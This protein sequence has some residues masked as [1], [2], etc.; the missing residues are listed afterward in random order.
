MRSYRTTSTLQRGSRGQMLSARLRGRRPRV[1]HGTRLRNVDTTV[2]TLAQDGR[3]SVACL[4]WPHKPRGNVVRPPS[5]W[6]PRSLRRRQELL[7]GASEASAAASSRP[8]PSP[9]PLARVAPVFPS[10]L[11][12]PPVGLAARRRYRI[13]AAAQVVVADQRW[14]GASKDSSECQ[15]RHEESVAGGRLAA[16][17]RAGA[18]ARLAASGRAAG[19]RERRRGRRRIGA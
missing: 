5:P 17:P 7:P 4:R 9:R 15:G 16:R 19:R 3:P 2:A 13:G 8:A 1:D 18:S 11:A 6:E 14:E 10:L 12:P